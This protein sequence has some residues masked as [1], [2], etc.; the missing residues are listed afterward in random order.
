MRINLNNTVKIDKALADVNGKASAFTIQDAAALT[1][2]AVLA[3]R[4]LAEILPKSGWKG[5]KVRCHPAGPKSSSYRNTAKSTECVL[6]RGGNAWF[7][8]ECGE[9]RVHPKSRQ[10]CDITLSAA[11]TL[12]APLYAAK[13][14]TIN[15]SQ[16]K[17]AVG[18]SAHARIQLAAEAAKLAGVA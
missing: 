6:E 15:F 7:L 9:G 13:R 18:L 11:Q 16:T 4:K 10:F 14:L 17:P 8:T 12:A 5:A 2:Y 1:S 3:E